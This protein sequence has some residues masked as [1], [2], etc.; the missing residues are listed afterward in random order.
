MITTITTF[1]IIMSIMMMLR[2]K[3]MLYVSCTG[4]YCHHYSRSG[5]PP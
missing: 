5:L 2:G 1:I 4:I 3:E